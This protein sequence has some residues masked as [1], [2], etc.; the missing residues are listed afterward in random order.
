MC[1]VFL[2]TIL[3]FTMSKEGKVMDLKKVKAFVNMLVPIIPQ[4]IRVF[5]RMAHFY[6]YFTKN[7]ASIMSLII[8]LLKKYEAFE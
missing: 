2:G 4:E 1:M 7:F 8:K 3:S 5:N 6:R